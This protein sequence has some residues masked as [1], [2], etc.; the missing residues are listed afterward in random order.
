MSLPD[1]NKPDDVDGETWQQHLE[2]MKVMESS[3]QHGRP[4]KQLM[5]DYFVSPK[6][7]EPPKRD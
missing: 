3:R 7:D 5:D 6:D 1:Y 2:W 4:L